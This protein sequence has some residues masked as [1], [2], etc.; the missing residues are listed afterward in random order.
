MSSALEAAVAFLRA[1]LKDG[2]IPATTVTT[3]AQAA[4]ISGSTLRRARKELAVKPRQT[5][6]GWIWTLK[7]PDGHSTWAG[8]HRTEDDLV[9]GSDVQANRSD[10]QRL[11]GEL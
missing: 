7:R 10:V 4:G 6:A 8:D 2:P 9:T 1:E 11:L 3:Y 5:A